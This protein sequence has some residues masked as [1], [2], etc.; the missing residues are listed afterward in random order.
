MQ[1]AF[2]AG[3]LSIWIA[4]SAIGLSS[5][6]A[7][8]TVPES[9]NQ[10]GPKVIE[11][12]KIPA[13]GD[14]GEHVKHLQRA[15][16]SKGSKLTIDGAF[17]AYTRDQVSRVQKDHGL[18]GSG[19]IGPKTL[20]ILDLRV[21]A[22][23]PGPTPV[24]PPPAGGGRQKIIQIA[25]GSACAKYRFKDRGTAPLGY[26]KGMAILY[27][28]G[29]CDR[30]GIVFRHAS[31]PMSLR[32]N[33]KGYYVDALKHYEGIF[34]D[35]GMSNAT[36]GVDTFRHVMTLMIGLGMRE[37]SGKYCCGRD[38]SA[39]NVTADTAEAGVMQT[40]WNSRSSNS[41]LVKLFESYRQPSSR[42]LL[43]VF[44]E[45]V[46]ASYCSA[47]QLKNWGDP[48]S[49]GFLF[50]KR[51]KESPALAVEYATVLIR[52]LGG[53]KGHYGPLREKKA[54]VRPECA[55]M[56]REVEKALEE[57]PTICSQVL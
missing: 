10:S 32:K 50:Q 22:P 28:R 27:A 37:S 41:D 34:S 8:A 36:A 23:V 18:P 24:P 56:L 30:S 17:G 47:S 53:E 16:N 26:M 54:E 6:A 33:S 5:C 11:I 7:T 45:G 57:D 19:V 35:A 21:V 25:S 49:T 13:F 42:D 2:K 46:S 4:V 55:S 29:L 40:S 52:S 38:G 43:E 20:E 12:S 9:V 3:L 14:V 15:L 48:A 39:S 31:Q 1:H 51:Q 44:R